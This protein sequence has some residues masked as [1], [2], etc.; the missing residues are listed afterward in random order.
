MLIAFNEIDLVN[1]IAGQT[2]RIICN[3]KCQKTKKS[4]DFLLGMLFLLDFVL[5][6][7]VI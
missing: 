4:K 5:L 6:K 7:G 3:N 1:V 2:L